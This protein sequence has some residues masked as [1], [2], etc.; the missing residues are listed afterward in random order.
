MIVEASQKKSMINV[1]TTDRCRSML[2]GWDGQL[3][4]KWG[5][6]VAGFF[7]RRRRKKKKK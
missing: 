5:A 7:F 1:D 4:N 6:G 2:A 3:C